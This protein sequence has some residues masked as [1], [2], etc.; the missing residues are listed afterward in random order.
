VCL[1]VC[2][3]FSDFWCVVVNVESERND[4][5]IRIPTFASA[6]PLQ[7]P[8]IA[9]LHKNKP[10][11]H[12]STTQF[13]NTLLQITS[14]TLESQLQVFQ[15]RAGTCK[16]EQTFLAKYMSSKE[17][18]RFQRCMQDLM[19]ELQFQKRQ[20]ALELD[21]SLRK[22][23]LQE[24]R[25]IRLRT[26]QQIRK[27]REE[28]EERQRKERDEAMRNRK[29]LAMRMAQGTKKAIRNLKDTIRDMQNAAET[30]MDEEEQRMAKNIRNKNKE[31]GAG[32]R[33]ECLRSIQFTIGTKETDTHTMQNEHLKSKGLPHFVR[34]DRSIGSQI[35]IWL[36][37]TFDNSRFISEIELSHR[38]TD[39]EYFKDYSNKKLWEYVD[40][41]PRETEQDRLNNEAVTKATGGRQEE[42]AP[43]EA[44]NDAIKVIRA[45]DNVIPLRFWFRRNP[46]SVTCVKTLAVT[47]TEEEEHRLIVDG[48]TK[49]QP[50]LSAFGLPTSSLWILKLERAKKAANTPVNSLIAEI[51]NGT[52][53]CAICLHSTVVFLS[54]TTGCCCCCCCCCC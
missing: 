42:S 21:L 15:D 6:H 13:A 11:T 32:S 52:F 24:L 53:S 26:L 12:C 51:N 50:D 37:S 46:K 14:M 28:R 2:L 48:Y 44:G 17:K 39:N 25:E 30:A 8:L 47:F 20:R 27:E 33:P 9:A 4:I 19:F 31:G 1:F 16:S 29:P 38:D 34:M 5:D 54:L 3:F 43:G 18:E 23:R 49:L 40:A 36:Q 35:Y 45:K 41:D 7:I 22:D 10:R